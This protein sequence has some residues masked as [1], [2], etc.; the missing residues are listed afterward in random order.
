MTNTPSTSLDEYV[1]HGSII[2]GWFNNEVVLS[3]TCTSWAVILG[4]VLSASEDLES[5]VAR[6]T[7]LATQAFISRTV[8][9][10]QGDGRVFLHKS[11]GCLLILWSQTFT[12]T[13]PE[14]KREK[15]SHEKR[16]CV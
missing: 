4:T 1:P 5:W 8:N 13:T 9:L 2:Q 11:S 3:L 16:S 7:I 15:E 10:G 6:D 12:V 14:R